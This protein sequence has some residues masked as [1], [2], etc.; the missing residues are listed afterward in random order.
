MILRLDAIKV[1][2]Q[3]RKT[4]RKREMD[5]NETKLG[6]VEQFEIQDQKSSN[7]ILFSDYAPSDILG[8]VRVSQKKSVSFGNN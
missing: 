7:V 8:I 6:N 1:T 4:A 3:K 5:E 2:F